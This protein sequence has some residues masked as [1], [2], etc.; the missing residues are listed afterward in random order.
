MK[1]TRSRWTRA[2][3]MLALLTTL[4][5]VPAGAQEDREA[6]Q[7][8]RCV[9][10]DGN[11]IER[12]TCFTLP[13]MDGLPELARAFAF[14]FGDERPRVGISLD[15]GQ[16]AEVDA[17][18][19]RIEDVLD[20]GPADEAGLR[21]GDVVVRFDGHDLLRSLGAEREEDFDLDVSLPV[22]RLL[23][24]A[25]E[26]EEGEVAEVE[27]LRGDERRTARVEA[28]ALDGWGARAFRVPRGE[29]LRA[30]ERLPEVGAFH[31]RRD[32]EGREGRAPGLRRF[33]LLGDGDGPGV[34][35]RGRGGFDRCPVPAGQEEGARTWVFADDCVGGLRLV[36][37]NPSLGAYFGTEEG[38]LV[39]DV[40][41]ESR[42]GLQPGDVILRIGDRE[43]PT[44]ERVRAVLRSYGEDEPVTLTVVREGSTRDVQ[45]RMGG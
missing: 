3:P 34:V 16:G 9:D 33:E 31:F 40:H 45:G 18:G 43:T 24:L 41:P 44:P 30:L 29:G 4:A 2:V 28:R 19:A 13:D 35:L 42:L 25:R 36:A 26:L 15:V 38:V 32:G 39:A 22:Q 11:E 10:A 5:A 14:S 37:L 8:C 17:R 7:E 20:D 21:A 1:T 27:Y 6:R 12:C 23:A